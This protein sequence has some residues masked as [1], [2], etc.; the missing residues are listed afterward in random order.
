MIRLKAVIRIIPST[1]LLD[2]RPS[3]VPGLFLWRACGA[4]HPE[5]EGVSPPPPQSIFSEK[6][7]S[8]RFFSAKIL[9]PE[10]FIPRSLAGCGGNG[11][12]PPAAMH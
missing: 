11:L 1:S 5:D 10:A 7:E 4:F 8:A 2:F 12:F 9:P 3:P 6:K